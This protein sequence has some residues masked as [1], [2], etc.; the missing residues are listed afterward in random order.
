MS[1]IIIRLKEALLEN[2]GKLESVPDRYKNQQICGKGVN[3]YL[4]AI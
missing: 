3:T 2:G 4:S 1:L